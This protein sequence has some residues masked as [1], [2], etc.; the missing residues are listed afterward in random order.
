MCHLAPL[1]IGS[2]GGAFVLRSLRMGACRIRKRV[3]R[4]SH[5]W[6]VRGGGVAEEAQ[7]GRGGGAAV[8]ARPRRRGG[9]GAEGDERLRRGEDLLQREEACDDDGDGAGDG[10]AHGDDADVEL[11]AAAQLAREVLVELLPRR[12]VARWSAAAHL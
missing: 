9:G 5:A 2:S 1:R 12:R 4:V 8:E 6:Q 11:E 10:H 3:P 7:W